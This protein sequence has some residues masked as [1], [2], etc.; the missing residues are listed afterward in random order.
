MR[1]KRDIPTDLF[2]YPGMRKQS[3]ITQLILVGLVLE[4]DDEGRGLACAELLAHALNRTVTQIEEA[5]SALEQIGMLMCYQAGRY[6]YY[7]LTYWRKWQRIRRPLPSRYPA[8]PVGNAGRKEVP[9][10]AQS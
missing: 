9:H 1:A 10:G 7:A 8:P 2:E 6:R 5:L 4:A 3:C